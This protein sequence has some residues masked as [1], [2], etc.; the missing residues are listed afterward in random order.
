[1]PKNNQDKSD[2]SDYEYNI[3][4]SR[5]RLAYDE[6]DKAYGEAIDTADAFTPTPN[7]P[8]HRVASEKRQEKRLHAKVNALRKLSHAAYVALGEA[9]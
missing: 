7:A 9:L 8:P 3:G 4:V 5:A 6:A 2:M 1:M